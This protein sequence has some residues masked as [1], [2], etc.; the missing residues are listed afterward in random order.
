MKFLKIIEEYYR[1]QEYINIGWAE[2]GWFN[3]SLIELMA[4]VYLLEL[5]FGIK[6][7]GELIPIALLSAF[8]LFYNF[9]RFLKKKKIY[10]MAEYVSARI[11]PIQDKLLRAAEIIIK[12]YDKNQQNVAE[13]SL[14]EH[15]N[16]ETEEE[17]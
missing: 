16:I 15:L 9:G 2:V 4:I 13:Q 12:E 14:K 7:Q 6:V 8:I 3:S 11:N 5:T 17:Q 10:D 1:T